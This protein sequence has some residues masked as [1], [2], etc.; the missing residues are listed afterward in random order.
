MA[1]R[2]PGICGFASGPMPFGARFFAWLLVLLAAGLPGCTRSDSRLGPVLRL[3]QAAG[4][5]AAHSWPDYTDIAAR[6]E[7]VLAVWMAPKGASNSDIVVRRSEDGGRS[8]SGEV[9]PNRPDFA[10]TISVSPRI[11]RFP[12]S[13]SLL[14]VWQSR[15]NRIGKKFVVVRRSADGG[16]HFA[17]AVT[18]NSQPQ[19][20]LP[21]AA[22][23]GAGEVVI[24]WTD[25]RRVSRD[26]FANRSMDGG[27]SW[28][29]QDVLLSANLAADAGEPALALGAAA[30]S[31]LVWEERAVRGRGK[32][33]PPHLLGVR[34]GDRG[35]TWSA[36]APVQPEPPRRSPL[37]P[38]LVESGGR[39]SLV[40]AT[41][42]A[43][44]VT[45]G[46]LFL[47]Q[48]TDAGRSWSAAQTIFAGEEAPF[49]R[50]QSDGERVYLVWHG[51]PRADIGIYFQASDDGGATWRT[52]WTTLLRLDTSPPDENALRPALGIGEDGVLA[53]VWVEAHRRVVLRYSTDAGRTWGDPLLVAREE[54][55]GTLQHPRIAV[56]NGRA[57]IIWERW[58]DKSKYVKTLFDVDKP[59]PKDLFVRSV[60]L[61]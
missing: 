28:L 8:W 51:G 37:W 39:Y 18:L 6:G 59:T 52:P 14:L 60:D 21:I 43:G 34:S 26:I 58:P 54:G 46:Q 15:R 4:D 10:D 23:R 27:R 3:N 32:T 16:R 44:A 49:Y 5:S 33:G 36:P 30:E 41:A 13:D 38:K 35:K 47:A 29:A 31:V 56:S 50:I 2:R 17:P 45:E 57:H 53:I 7:D 9:R 42:L 48:S 40:W 20:F 25:E 24:A 1:G 55:G 22:S 11:I 61:R 12:A 19:A